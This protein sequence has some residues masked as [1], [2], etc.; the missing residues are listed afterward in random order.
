MITLTFTI[1]FSVTSASEKISKVSSWFI[2][3]LYTHH[4]IL[5][6]SLGPKCGRPATLHE[7]RPSLEARTTTTSRLEDL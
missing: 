2:L 4:N 1:V 6:L 3:S 7:A 5:S